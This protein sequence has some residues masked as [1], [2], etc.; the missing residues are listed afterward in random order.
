MSFLGGGGKKFKWKNYFNIRT[1]VY[2]ITKL[3]YHQNISLQYH[4]ILP[5]I[6][7]KKNRLKPISKLRRTAKNDFESTALFTI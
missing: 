2:N 1:S 3:F 6:L 7:T 5:S 4:K